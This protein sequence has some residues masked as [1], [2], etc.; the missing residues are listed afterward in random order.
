MTYTYQ[1]GADAEEEIFRPVPTKGTANAYTEETL[2]NALTGVTASP[3]A[4]LLMLT[5]SAGAAA[6]AL[7]VRRRTGRR[8]GK[9]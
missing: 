6:A 5:V 9:Q 7:F 8:D 3:A 1:E 4:A 2:T